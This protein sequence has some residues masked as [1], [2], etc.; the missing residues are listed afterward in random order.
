MNRILLVL[1]AF[2]GVAGLSCERSTDPEGPSL[3]DLYGDFQ[4]LEAFEASRQNVDFSNGS[5]MFFTAFFSKQVNWRITITG[6]SSGAAKVIE[7]FTFRIT[8]ENSTWIGDITSLPMMKEEPCE[9][10]LNVET[11]DTN[12]AD[13]IFIN[14]RG[15]K[16]NQGKLVTDFE[17]GLNPGFIRFVQSGVPPMIFDTINDVTSAQGNA[18]YEM[19]GEVPFA[20]D[21]GNIL[22]PKSSFTD[23]AFELPPNDQTVYFNFFAR[24]GPMTVDELFVFQFMEDDDGNGE[25]NAGSDDLYEYVLDGLPE[26]WEHFSVKYADIVGSSLNGNQQRDPDRLIQMRLLPISPP[27]N[28]ARIQ[29]FVDYMIFTENTPL[30]P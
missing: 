4:V 30:R 13:T 24:K 14:V 18:C 11:L 7:G 15:V 16:A 10:V 6:Q 20:D 26:E 5:T 9:V 12:F 19:S 8:E 23:T 1:I 28:R 17:N 2:L 29:T 3:N 25:Y 27:P 22:M 21:L